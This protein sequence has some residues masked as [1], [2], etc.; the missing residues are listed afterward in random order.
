[1]DKKHVRAIF[2][3]SFDPLT[4]GHL[5]VIERGMKLFDELVVAVGRSPVKNQLFTPEER[6]EM[7]A[8]LLEEKN[9]SGVLVESFEGLTVAY[10]ARK[11]ADVILR[12]LRSLTDVQYEFQLAMTNRAV[13]GIETIFIMT[14]E[15]F[16][17]TSSTLI[18]EVASLGGDLSNLIPK[19]IF[20]HVKKKSGDLRG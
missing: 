5:D 1:M 19:N 12:G 18:R 8:E 11:K 7:I 20:E 13:A 16:G 10:A 17:F 9:M 14:S 2:P 4:N 3:G 15:Q 6:V